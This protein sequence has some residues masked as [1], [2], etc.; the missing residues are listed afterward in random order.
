MREKKRKKREQKYP[1]NVTHI[2][3]I[4][5]RRKFLNRDRTV[6]FVVVVVTG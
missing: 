1:K 4:N 5:F 2:Y 6:L 3:Y